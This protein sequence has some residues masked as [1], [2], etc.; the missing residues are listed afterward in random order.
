MLAR[1]FRLRAAFARC[2]VGEG[3]PPRF[4]PFAILRALIV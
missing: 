2:L 3:P 4:A 1:H